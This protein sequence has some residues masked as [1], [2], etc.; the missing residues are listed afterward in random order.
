MDPDCQFGTGC[1]RTFIYGARRAYHYDVKVARDR[2]KCQ[3]WD[4][5]GTVERLSQSIGYT[6]NTE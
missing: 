4:K 2:A 5:D 6:D 1:L 3:Q